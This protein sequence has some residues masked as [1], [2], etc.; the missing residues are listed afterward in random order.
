MA[1]NDR[2]DTRAGFD[3]AAVD[4]TALGRHLWHPIGEAT[5]AVAGPGTGDRVLDACCGTG[6]TALPA[7]QLVGPDGAVDAV[8]LSGPMVGEL[9]RLTAHQAD[10][11]T[12]PVDG[13]DVVLCVLGIFFFPDMTA[14]TE[15]LVRRARYPLDDINQPGPYADWL[16]GR[17]LSD[18]D[19]TVHE[20]A[21]PMTP[22]IAWLVVIGSGYRAELD[23][24]TLI[25]TGSAGASHL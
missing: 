2:P 19:V 21:L 6:A 4:F 7:A 9:P 1:D 8:D 13:Y 15:H 25:G 5:V 16:A 24:T 22:E 14:G 12:W 17:G 18:V 23:A 3:A 11:T 10:V 20:L